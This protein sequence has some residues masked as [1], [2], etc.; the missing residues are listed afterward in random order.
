MPRSESR[1]P[2]TVSVLRP[3][4]RKTRVETHTVKA[5]YDN[6]VFLQEFR[7]TT[8]Q[9]LWKRSRRTSAALQFL[10]A[11]PRAPTMCGCSGI[12]ASA[13][14]RMAVHAAVCPSCR[15]AYRQSCASTSRTQDR[16]RVS[17]WRCPAAHPK[18]HRKCSRRWNQGER[19]RLR[20]DPWTAQGEQIGNEQPVRQ[21]WSRAG[22]F[23]QWARSSA[24][25]NVRRWLSL[26][27]CAQIRWCGGRTRRKGGPAAVG[28]ARSATLRLDCFFLRQPPSSTVASWVRCVSFFFCSVKK[29]HW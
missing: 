11:P 14:Q 5:M 29:Q 28:P 15:Q 4:V 8:K 16:V 18:L 2:I 25:L 13:L 26:Q 10:E 20:A 22:A 24:V 17:V 23:W 27:R 1:L 12:G 3:A 7:T 9:S 19:G 6:R 21:I